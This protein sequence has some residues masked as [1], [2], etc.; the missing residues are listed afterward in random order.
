[1][2]TR[3]HNE[4]LTR[5]GP[6]T[7]MGGLLRRYWHPIATTVDLDLDPVR[8][9]RLLGE[10]LTLFRSESGELGLIGERCPHRGVDLEYGIPDAKGL[11]CPYHGWLFDTKGR[12]LEMPFDDRIRQNDKRRERIGIEAYP[13]QELGGL[14]FVYLGPEPVPLLPRWDVLARPEFH[15]AVQIHMLPCNWLQ[16]MDNS[17]DPVHFEYLHAALGNYTLKKQGKPPAMKFQ[18]HVKIGFDRFKYGLM[19]RRL[20]EGESEDVDDW[21][22]GHPLLFPNI[23]AQGAAHAPTLQFRT[24]VDDTHTLHFGY[25]TRLRM[26]DEPPKFTAVREELFDR[27]GKV[28]ADNIPQQDMLAWVAQG[29]ISDRT[30]EHLAAS[31]TGIALFR[32]MLNEALEA[33][34]RGE[35]P[36]GV[37]RDAKE[38]EPWIDL[39]REAE[40]LKSF[41]STYK[42]LFDRIERV[43]ATG[44]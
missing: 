42:G 1:M 25:R 3:Q 26:S 18:R 43:A 39:N 8:R 9:V 5:V 32:R 29:P 36:I 13:A 20:L 44:K 41:D 35:D 4:R 38:N 37:I 31:D 28:V 24:P 23:L 33:V 19:K 22:T 15:R 17:A 11:R 7:P 27:H 21:T 14:I 34:A 2:M 6:C 10:N 40:T 12:C 16:C 30:R